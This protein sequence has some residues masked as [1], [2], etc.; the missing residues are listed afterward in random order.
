MIRFSARGA[1]LLLVAQ[2]RAL[3]VEG[4]LISFLTKNSASV[5]KH[6]NEQQKM[7]NSTTTKKGWVGFRTL[8]FLSTLTEFLIASSFSLFSMF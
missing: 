4:A 1:Y 7:Y 3:I 5:K 8:F 2:G 6:L